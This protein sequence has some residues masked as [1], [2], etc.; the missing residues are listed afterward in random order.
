[1]DHELNPTELQQ[2]VGLISKTV[3]ISEIQPAWPLTLRVPFTE[4]AQVRA[5]ADYSGRSINQLLTHLLRVGL[6]ALYG[7]LPVEDQLGLDL[8]RSEVVKELVKSKGGTVHEP[9]QEG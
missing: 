7:A 4:Y 1:M 3:K 2:L 6:N 9:Y 5:L 8:V